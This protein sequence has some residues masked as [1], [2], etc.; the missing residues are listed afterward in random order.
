MELLLFLANIIFTLIVWGRVRRL[1]RIIKEK[2]SEE[3]LG[4]LAKGLPLE[5]PKPPQLLSSA[6]LHPNGDV[7]I[8]V[9]KLI[10]WLKRDWLL[11]LGALLLLLGFAWF[12]TYAFANNW[13]GPMGRIALGIIAGVCFIILGWWRIQKYLHQGSVFLALGSTIVL[14][15][16]YAAR[17]VYHFFTPLSALAVMFLS[18]V[19]VALASVKYRNRILALASLILAGI[20]PLL[21]ST[22]PS[23][24]NYVGL[25]SYLLV[26]V[27]GVVWVVFVTGARELTLIALI[28]VTLYS[29]PHL[30]GYT[31]A[32]RGALLLFAYAFTAVFFLT[33]TAGVLK[34]KGK[35]LIP[36]L[37]TAGGNG[38]FLLAWISIAA[39][40][41]WAS[42]IIAAWLVVFTVGA[43]L[44]FRTTQ[45]REPFYVYAGVAV[46]FLAAATAA[47]LKGPLLTIAYTL[48]SGAILLT[49]YLVLK[50]VQVATRVSLLLVGPVILSV[51][52]LT[53]GAWMIGV[54]HEHFSVL[55]ILAATF[56]GLGLFFLQR[57]ADENKSETS[58][59]AAILLIVGSFYAY[60][61]L[62]LSL[63]AALLNDN[64]AVM[65][66]LTIYTIIGLTAYFYGLSQGM[67]VLWVY[68]G[69]LV[70]FVVGRLLLVEVWRMELGIRV[71]T[72]FLIGLLLIGTAFLTKEEA[73]KMLKGSK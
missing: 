66:A 24:A 37:V 40:K 39:S 51:N 4:V 72:F 64:V 60:A 12:A 61:L 38:L 69:V 73:K 35:E 18:T 6:P 46:A 1:E 54:F 21:T 31:L 36:D 62:W 10:E 16:I 67:R 44:T 25:F 2:G 34:L 55:L 7:L 28:I 63:H 14:L 22:T 65:I 17:T 3:E 42:L 57:L 19:F 23:P 49:T 47:E 27:A 53:A 33:N 26:V 43:F 68:G 5:V 41:E 9:E 20:A 59:L 29:L 13:I 50:D 56:F 45:Q 15:T 32:D 48:E 71:I 30:L 8:A 11:K 70:G 58:F 52:S